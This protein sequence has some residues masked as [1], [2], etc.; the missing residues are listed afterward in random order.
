MIYSFDFSDVD[1]EANILHHN[2]PLMYSPEVISRRW[3]AAKRYILIQ[4]RWQ[5]DTNMDV[6]GWIA[7]VLL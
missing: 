3:T 6:A 1:R 7:M 4:D 5:D 2:I